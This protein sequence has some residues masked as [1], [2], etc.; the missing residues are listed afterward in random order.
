M[1]HIIFRRVFGN[2]K[3]KKFTGDIRKLKHLKRVNLTLNLLGSIEK[4]GSLEELEIADF[5]C[6]NI[7]SVSEVCEE[8]KEC[9]KLND[10]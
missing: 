10:L 3:F 4:L 1:Y 6:N 5:S 8:L 7:A 2:L 9:L